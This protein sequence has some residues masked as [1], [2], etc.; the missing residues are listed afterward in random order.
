MGSAGQGAAGAAG[1]GGPS[2]DSG[3]LGKGILDRDLPR[4]PR[5]VAE[6]TFLLLFSE[7]VQYTQT[8]SST[9]DEF[10]DRL[11]RMGYRAGLRFAEMAVGRSGGKLQRFPDII[12]ALR[13]ISSSLWKTLFGKDADGLEQATSAVETCLLFF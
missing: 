10:R 7:V 12:S 6:S 8:H 9:P 4:E 11:S 5:R 2:G 13:Y 3:G 1:A